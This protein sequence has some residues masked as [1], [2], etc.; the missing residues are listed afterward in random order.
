[1]CMSVRVAVAAVGFLLVACADEGDGNINTAA[2]CEQAGGRVAPNL[3]PGVQC[4]PN[5]EQIGTVTEPLAYEAPLC[6]RAK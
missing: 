1:M 4:E 3:G 5:E 2:E 6:C